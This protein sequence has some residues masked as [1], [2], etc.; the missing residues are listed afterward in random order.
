MAGSA[1]HRRNSV[2]WWAGA[3]WL[4]SL[5]MLHR[6]TTER[7]QFMSGKTTWDG[8]NGI[9]PSTMTGASVL[10]RTVFSIYGTGRLRLK[11][12]SRVTWLLLPSL[13]KHGGAIRAPGVASGGKG[14]MGRR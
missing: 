7:R 6:R 9:N 8:G 3:G 1:R 5:L 11:K 13:S 12:E 2:V 10:G 4:D 14:L